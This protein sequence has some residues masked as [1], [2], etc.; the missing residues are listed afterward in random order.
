MLF[1]LQR[2]CADITG[3][4]KVK[5][6]TRNALQKEVSCANPSLDDTIKY[7]QSESRKKYALPEGFPAV[8]SLSLSPFPF[9]Y[10]YEK[11][12]F[13]FILFDNDYDESLQ[14]NFRVAASGSWS[15]VSK[16]EKDAVRT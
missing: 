8:L 10:S 6:L 14:S 5:F 2:A 12:F 11:N 3:C 15:I 7:L 1:N 16:A 4:I 13:H 9:F